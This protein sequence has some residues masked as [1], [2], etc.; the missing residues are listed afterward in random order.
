[1]LSSLPGASGRS[2]S[3]WTDWRSATSSST[4]QS[5]Y[6]RPR[7]GD[8]AD[9]ALVVE[10]ER[11]HLQPIDE[12]EPQPLI[13]LLQDP[14][15][16]IARRHDPGRD[17]E[18]EARQHPGQALREHAPKLRRERIHA[19]E[20]LDRNTHGERGELRDRLALQRAAPER[21]REDQKAR[22]GERRERRHSDQQHR[23]VSAN[24]PQQRQA[25]SHHAQ[26]PPKVEVDGLR[27]CCSLRAHHRPMVPLRR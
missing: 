2:S 1:M 3:R 27:S 24:S 11:E 16:V 20:A 12:L 5:R 6:R 17:P 25:A 7:H 10:A 14:D 13:H 21:R 4:R 18:R 22:E 23:Q 19:R 9:P 8:G 15:P 26:L